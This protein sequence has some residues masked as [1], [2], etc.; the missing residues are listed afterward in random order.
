M[1]NSSYRIGVIGLGYVGLPLAVE[2]SK[3]HPVVGFDIN[4]RRIDELQQCNDYTLEVDEPSLKAVIKDQVPG[5]HAP[6]SCRWRAGFASGA[7]WSLRVVVL[8]RHRGIRRFGLVEP[9]GC[10]SRMASAAATGETACA[11]AAE[12]T[13]TRAKRTAMAVERKRFLVWNFI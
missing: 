8:N 12:P 3:Y 7:V 2:F 4:K 9:Q 10:G 13:S 5:G 1:G 11:F 6:A